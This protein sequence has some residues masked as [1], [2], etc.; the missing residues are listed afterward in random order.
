MLRKLLK[1]EF[2][3]TSRIL[4]PLYGALLIFALINKIFFFGTSP[5]KNVNFE[6]L[7]GIPAAISIFTYGATM[8]AVFIVTI[9]IIIQRFYKNLLGDE[10]YLMNTL[11]VSISSNISSKLISAI[12]WSLISIFV[13]VL[14]IIIMVYTREGFNTFLSNISNIFS[15]IYTDTGISTI[16]VGIEFLIAGLFQLALNIT[17]IYAS[18]SIGHLLPKM[19]IL[20]SFGA[21]IALNII[22]NTVLSSIMFIFRDAIANIESSLGT[23]TLT[24]LVAIG[25]ILINAIWFTIYFLTTR[26]ILKN[27]LNLE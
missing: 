26:Y 7:H 3:A 20:G 27:R 13:A 6:F 2:K 24:H 8:A 1:Y 22:M 11:P 19:K 18:I 15:K 10:G 16:L 12:V 25:A 5:L 17:L 14:S 4:L 9:F 23:V 21:F